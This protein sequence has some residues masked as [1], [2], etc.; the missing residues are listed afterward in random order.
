MRTL[1][2]QQ[3]SKTTLIASAT[4]SVVTATGTAGVV[5]TAVE[6]TI[7]NALIADVATLNNSLNDLKAK[8]RIAGLLA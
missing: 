8:M 7:I 2:A 5:Y 4:D 1:R 3:G 6:Q